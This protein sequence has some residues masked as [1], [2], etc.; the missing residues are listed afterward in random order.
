MKKKKKEIVA[1]IEKG[2]NSSFEHLWSSDYCTQRRRKFFFETI[3][4]KN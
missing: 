1:P 2:Q 3:E 4:N